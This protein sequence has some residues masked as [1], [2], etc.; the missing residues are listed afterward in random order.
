MSPDTLFWLTAVVKVVASAAFVVSASVATERAGPVIGSL[1]ATLPLSSGPAYVLIALD[2]SDSF[3]ASSA[4][5][6]ATLHSAS[7]FFIL[8]YAA[9]AQRHGV[10]LSLVAGVGLW[11]ILAAISTAF[12]WTPLGVIALNVVTFLVCIPLGRRFLRNK[13]PPVTRRWYDIPMRAG[14]VSCIAILV[15]ALGNFVGP[16]LTGIIA[17]FPVIFTSLIII[18][19][20]RIGGP[21]TAGVIANGMFGL[22]GFAIGLIFLSLAAVPLGKWNALLIAFAITAAW[23]LALFALWR[24]RLFVRLSLALE[25]SSH[26]KTLD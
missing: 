23:N 2:H 22:V 17:V 24:S 5:A 19:H 9:L 20:P 15:L 14:M 21:A 18:L 3:I 16:G 1:I 6:S 8:V 4:L 26:R 11:G 10:I 13:M 7:I 12:T 25:R